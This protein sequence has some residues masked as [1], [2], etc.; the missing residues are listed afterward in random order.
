MK[1]TRQ[2][3]AQILLF[4]RDGKAN[5]WKD[6]CEEFGLAPDRHDTRHYWLR[7]QLEALKEVGL[8]EFKSERK[9]GRIEGAIRVADSWERI[10]RVLAACG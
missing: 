8:I 6:L 4:I 10:Q 7:E 1:L 2:S 9:E 3:G 5:T